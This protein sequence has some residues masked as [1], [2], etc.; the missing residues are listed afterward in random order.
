VP[1]SVTM[2]ERIAIL[3]DWAKTRARPASSTPEEPVASQYDTAKLIHNA[4][5][6]HEQDEPE[7]K[8]E[9][10][11]AQIDPAPPDPAEDKPAG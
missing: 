8:E 11:F 7:D 10:R 3:R 5:F 1:L 6:G 9:D 2:A 4:L